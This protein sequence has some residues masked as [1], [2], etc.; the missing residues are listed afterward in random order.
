[1]TNIAME[2]MALIEIDDVPSE[3][4]LHLWLGFSMAMLGNVITRLI[5]SG[6][7]TS[8]SDRFTSHGGSVPK[9]HPFSHPSHRSIT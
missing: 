8:D 5:H 7:E 3:L 6:P 9:T 1:M 2:A 4:N